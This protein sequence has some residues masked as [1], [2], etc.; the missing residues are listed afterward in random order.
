M[1]HFDSLERAKVRNHTIVT[2]GVFDG[3]HRGHQHLLR[4]LVDFARQAQLIPVVVTFFPYPD[5]V[6]NGFVPG[7]YLTL[8]ELKA[9]L[10]C[11][12]GIEVVVTQPFDDQTRHLRATDFVSK[13]LVHLDMEAMWVGAD[14]AMGYKR[15]GDVGFLGKAAQQNGFGLRVIDLIDADGE[16][17]SS[18]LI[19][20]ALA[21]GDVDAASHLLGRPHR[22]TGTVV[23]GAGRGKSIGIPT[24]NISFPPEA[25][26]PYRGVYAA[27]VLISNIV[28]ANAVVNI[29]IRPTFDGAGDQ[30]V[31]A[32]LLNFSSDL[33]AQK[34]SL[35]FIS[36]L[37]DEQKF[38]NVE[39]LVHQI[40][41]DKQTA[42]DVF[43][44]LGIEV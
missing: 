3:V 2:I 40:G 1:I 42:V 29:G 9:D 18:S 32:H 13:L 39:S 8:P 25:A 31:E 11:A 44:S 24:A 22:L 41:K 14:F 4:Q 7:Y 33:Y 20:R 35:D 16:R 15:E 17:I 30:I 19:R 26:V 34:I 37:R 43:A 28:M 36:R 21:T 10:L 38:E 6:I 12:L 23:H 27:R 5:L